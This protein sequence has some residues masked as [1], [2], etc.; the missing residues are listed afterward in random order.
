MADPKRISAPADELYD[1]LICGR[2]DLGERNIHGGDPDEALAKGDITARAV[3]SHFDRSDHPIGSRVDA[4]HGP[5]AL[6]ESPDRIFTAIQRWGQFLP[7]PGCP[8]L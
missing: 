8:E 4:R 3:E 6:I 7:S 2:V 5:V 1:H